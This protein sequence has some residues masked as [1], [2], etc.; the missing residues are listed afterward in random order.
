MFSI[1]HKSKHNEVFLIN[2]NVQNRETTSGEDRYVRLELNHSVVGNEG[3]INNGLTIAF[4][5]SI[6]KYFTIFEAMNIE[7]H[8]N[9]GL[10]AWLL[11][12]NSFALDWKTSILSKSYGMLYYLKDIGKSCDNIRGYIQLCTNNN[13]IDFVKF[14]QNKDHDFYNSNGVIMTKECDFIP[15]IDVACRRTYKSILNHF[16]SKALAIQ[17]NNKLCSI[18]LFKNQTKVINFLI[19]HD[20]IK[21]LKS[22]V[23][24]LAKITTTT[25]ICK[26]IF[27]K[28]IRSV[29]FAM[30]RLHGEEYKEA[31]IDV[32]EAIAKIGSIELMFNLVAKSRYKKTVRIPS[33]IIYNAFIKGDLD[34][35][36]YTL[37]TEPRVSMPMNIINTACARGHLNVISKLPADIMFSR[38]CVHSAIKSGNLVLFDEVKN[39]CIEN[40]FLF[41]M[42][43]ILYGVQSKNDNMVIEI[44]ELIKIQLDLVGCSEDITT[45]DFKAQMIKMK[46]LEEFIT[47]EIR[48]K[49]IINNLYKSLKYCDDNLF[50]EIFNDKLFKFACLKKS[51]ETIEIMLQSNKYTP[52]KMMLRQEFRKLLLVCKETPC[53]K[54]IKEQLIGSLK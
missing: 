32:M 17:K 25:G 11:E 4:W 8:L 1:I 20:R 33:S 14:F 27:K 36:V 35:W 15:T 23:P 10:K 53:W 45:H 28:K 40:P 37:Q 30:S 18:K 34:F 50:I 26:A 38:Q 29:I 9:I 47:I 16:I 7:Y 44:I 5:K 54:R 43:S 31:P 22:L 51:L 46:E 2:K 21:L 3:Q 41:D 39:N 19:E 13:L 49:L 42:K 48:Q 52:D 24:R 6:F 12:N